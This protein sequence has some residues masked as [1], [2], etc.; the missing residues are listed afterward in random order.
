M[1]GLNPGEIIGIIAAV[2]FTLGFGFFLYH[3]WKSRK[4]NKAGAISDKS[5]NVIKEKAIE[6]SPTIEEKLNISQNNNLLNNIYA[7][8]DTSNNNID[9]KSTN[10]KKTLPMEDFDNALFAEQQKFNKNKNTKQNNSDNN[11]NQMLEKLQ[12]SQNVKNVQDTNIINNNQNQNDQGNLYAKHAPPINIVSNG[13]SMQPNFEN[14]AMQSKTMY[15]LNNNIPQTD[16][17]YPNAASNSEPPSNP[18]TLQDLQNYNTPQIMPQTAAQQNQNIESKFTPEERKALINHEHIEPILNS[19][20]KKPTSQKENFNMSNNLYPNSVQNM[21]K[22][23]S[24]NP[25]LDLN[26]RELRQQKV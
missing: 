5:N 6:N 25:K 17:L 24:N 11:L 13:Q 4:T 12:N 8:N 21:Q 2:V 10:P 9:P 1:S 19:N 3:K 20:A 18:M 14:R 26:Q 7:I 22:I 23:N 16:H 15:P